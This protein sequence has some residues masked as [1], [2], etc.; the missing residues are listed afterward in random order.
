LA[1][2]VSGPLLAILTDS[3]PASPLFSENERKKRPPFLIKGGRHEKRRFSASGAV[4]KNY[5]AHS[6]QHSIRISAKNFGFE[7]SIK[8]VPRCN[9]K[10]KPKSLRPPDSG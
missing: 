7:N 4:G 8:S 2:A 1:L 9:S 3:S 5:V 10:A 6:P